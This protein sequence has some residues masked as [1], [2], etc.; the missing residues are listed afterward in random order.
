MDYLSQHKAAIK[1]YELA[2]DAAEEKHASFVEKTVINRIEVLRQ[3]LEAQQ[4][5]N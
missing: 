1:F 5:N 4:R 2:L 3:A